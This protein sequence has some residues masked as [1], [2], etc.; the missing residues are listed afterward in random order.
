MVPDQA[1]A[2]AVDALGNVYVAGYSV[3]SGTDVDYATIKCV[4]EAAPTPTPNTIPEAYGLAQHNTTALPTFPPRP[5][6]PPL[7]TPR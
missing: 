1:G 3:G 6:R 5:P 7:P 4:Q 2:I